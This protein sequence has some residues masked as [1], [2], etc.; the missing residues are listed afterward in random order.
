[1]EISRLFEEVSHTFLYRNF[2]PTLAPQLAASSLAQFP[3]SMDR[4]KSQPKTVHILEQPI[5][6]PNFQSRRSIRSNILI[7]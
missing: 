5:E 2:F 6:L 7:T 1:M 4:K 3:V